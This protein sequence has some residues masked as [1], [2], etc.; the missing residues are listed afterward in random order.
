M[1]DEIQKITNRGMRIVFGCSKKTPIRIMLITFNLMDV[2][3]RIIFKT[4]CIVYEMNELNVFR[5][6]NLG[7]D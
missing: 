5:I 7:F 2:E 6:F 4:L 3:Q 1:F